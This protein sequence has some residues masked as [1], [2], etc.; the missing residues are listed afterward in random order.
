MF[1]ILEQ[2]QK[3]RGE[4][5]KMQQTLESKTIEVSSGGRLGGLRD[6]F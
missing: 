3:I 5:E 6:G 4:M 2:A 1:N